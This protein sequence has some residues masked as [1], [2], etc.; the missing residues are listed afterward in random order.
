MDKLNKIYNVK[1]RSA[2]SVSYRIGTQRREFGPGETQRV[3]YE[4]LEKLTYIPGGKALIENR[5][6]ITDVEVRDDLSI[7]TQPESFLD[8]EEI[9]HVMNNGSLD[10][11]LDMLDFAP[12]GVI[13]LIK[14]NAVELPLNN[15]D[16]VTALKNKTGFDARVALVNN[17]VEK[18]EAPKAQR[19]VQAATEEEAPAAPARR[20]N[21]INKT[22]E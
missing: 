1:N 13:D 12:A 6:L 3:T 10:Q 8:E 14:K 15:L 22:E 7:N 17:Q 18:E 2:G 19:R 5:L 9:K 20:Y 16:K 4:E 11:F 21:I